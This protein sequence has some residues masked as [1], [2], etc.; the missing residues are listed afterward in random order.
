[1]NNPPLP[2]GE[3]IL[4]EKG[5]AFTGVG[6]SAGNSQRLA[7]EY[8]DSLQLEL[9]VIDARPASTETVFFGELFATPIM[10]TA[11]SALDRIRPN[12]MVEMAKG[13]KAAGAAMMVGIGSEDELAAIVDTGVKAI[14]IV[15]PY[16]DNELILR[17]LEH[18]GACGAFGVGMDVSYGFGMKNGFSPAPMSS[19]SFEEIQRFA[20]ATK[21][22][23]IVKGVLS[24]SDAVKAANAGA[25]GIMVSHQGGTVMDFCMPPVKMLPRIAAAI[26]RRI[27]IFVDCAFQ[28]G[29]DAFKGLALGADGIGVG[30]AVMAGLA[31]N[32]ADGVRSVLEDMTGELRRI[33]SLTG[34]AA[35]DDIDKSAVWNS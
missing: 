20:A 21:L 25:S 15:K 23:F 14:K 22:P 33:M 26:E 34:A 8:L 18:A 11:L 31:V 10:V 13:A 12:G 27:P 29:M 19:K 3:K 4:A 17:K 1:M 32:G 24:E 9:R 2:D 7:R 16:A 28:S 6:A 5:M 30:K 35:I